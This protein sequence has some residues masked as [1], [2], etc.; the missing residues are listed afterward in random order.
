MNAT[1]TGMPPKPGAAAYVAKSGVLHTWTAYSSVS[2]GKKTCEF[3]DSI[4][5]REEA[6]NRSR[7]SRSRTSAATTAGAAEGKSVVYCFGVGV[8]A[9]AGCSQPKGCTPTPSLGADKALVAL[10]GDLR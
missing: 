7:F 1:Q 8:Q 6:S 10:V 4:A 3:R 9:L 5:W 2:R